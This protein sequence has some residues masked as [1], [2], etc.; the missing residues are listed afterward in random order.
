MALPSQ[1]ARPIAR[2]SHY[3]ARHT[4]IRFRCAFGCE[5]WY[6]TA[7]H[8]G[9]YHLKKSWKLGGHSIGRRYLMY[10]IPK[11]EDAAPLPVNE[12]LPVECT[13][14]D[15]RFKDNSHLKFHIIHKH[16]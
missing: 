3:Y 1:T 2:R 16:L 15:M 6:S 14:C 4:K 10:A 8:L 7:N 12:T 9:Q 13:W 11:M 5:K